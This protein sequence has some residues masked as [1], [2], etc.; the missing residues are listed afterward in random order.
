MA[1]PIA[2]HS[3][4]N[5]AIKAIIAQ[6]GKKL[7]FIKTENNTVAVNQQ[8]IGSP[9]Y[10]DAS[11]DIEYKNYDGYDFIKVRAYD[12]FNRKTYSSLIRT[13]DIR[14]FVIAEKETDI[15]DGFRC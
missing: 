3:L 15:L 12:P 14:T 9:V 7:K 8:E 6:Y 5:D 1:G 11:T 10:I 4:S 2:E 13:H